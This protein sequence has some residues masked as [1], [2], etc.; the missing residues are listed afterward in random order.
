MYAHL[1]SAMPAFRASSREAVAIA[2]LINCRLVK[3]IRT[4]IALNPMQTLT[5]PAVPARTPP[6]IS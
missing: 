5:P 4:A 3:R 2:R 1:T 6:L